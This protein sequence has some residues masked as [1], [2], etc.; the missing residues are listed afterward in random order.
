MHGR[1]HGT[2]SV[3]LV[4]EH[5]TEA[6][7]RARP[8]SFPAISGR[9]QRRALFL[10][11]LGAV[12]IL[13]DP[14]SV[15]ADGTGRGRLF[16]P[17]DHF[18]PGEKLSISGTDLDPGAELVLRL[19]SGSTTVELGRTRVSDDRTFAASATVPAAFPPG[20]AELT[21]TDAAGTAWSTFIL[22]GDRAEGPDP[23][24]PGAQGPEASTDSTFA[25]LLLAIGLVVFVVAGLAHLRGRPRVTSRPG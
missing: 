20:Y 9:R 17:G 22:I 18:N 2:G 5:S 15:M 13:A 14:T 8:L 16:V 1:L 24:G 6:G 23:A 19:A 25:V 11:V 10:V 3:A 12:A 4:R 21:A 7:R